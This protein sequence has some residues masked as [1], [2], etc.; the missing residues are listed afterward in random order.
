M[1][2]STLASSYDK[3]NK[4]DKAFGYF[5]LA[6]SINFEINKNKLSK[7]RSIKLLDDRI[8]FFKEKN[9]IKKFI[10]FYFNIITMLFHII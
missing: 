3:I 5:E 7:D 8:D 10:I 2:Y 1:R 4:F 6:N 9:L